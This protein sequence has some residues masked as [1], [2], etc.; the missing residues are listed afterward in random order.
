MRKVLSYAAAL[1][2]AGMLLA[3][4]LLAA[5]VFVTTEH[6][7]LWSASDMLP[8]QQEDISAEVSALAEA[9]H[10]SGET[11]APY[12]AQA[13]EKHLHT[14]AA[15]WGDLWTDAVAD[16][17]LPMYL[18][19]AEERELVSA[20]MA[21]AAFAAAHDEAHLRAIAR[22]DVAYAL[23]TVV[24]ETVA[25]LRR[26]VV[27][28]ALSMVTERISLPMVRSAA[29]IAMVLLTI[30]AVALLVWQRGLAA[31]ILLASAIIT[32]SAPLPLLG[33]GVHDLLYQLNLMACDVW[34]FMVRW[35][36]AGWYGC[37]LLLA[38]AAL[39]IRK[40]GE[41]RR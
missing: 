19:A 29:C 16:A 38:A 22:D 32:G 23:D 9:W 14:L 8:A 10:V 12:A 24:C 26:S 41:M 28:L 30:A 21:D 5:F 25:P 35:L 15:W 2:T 1:L 3:A 34:Q 37:V 36:L 17:S 18:T 11:L 4:V 13:A 20:V 40:I 27:D 7:V 39:I 33:T 6:F 31:D